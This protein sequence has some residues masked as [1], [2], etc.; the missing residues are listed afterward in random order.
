MIEIEAGAIAVRV[1]GGADAAVV[2]RIIRA[3]KAAR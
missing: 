3:L 2:E 1:N